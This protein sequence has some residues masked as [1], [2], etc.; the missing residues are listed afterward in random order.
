MNY[1][2]LIY[3]KYVYMYFSH[4]WPLLFGRSWVVIVYQ[5]GVFP[6]GF[7]IRLYF[8][9][10]RIGPTDHIVPILAG[11]ASR[12]TDE[13]FWIFA[14]D[15]RTIGEIAGQHSGAA[16]D[17]IDHFVGTLLRKQPTEKRLCTHIYGYKVNHTF[18]RCHTNFSLPMLTSNSISVNW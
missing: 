9:C 14:D 6:M 15:S 4:L 8:R 16:I 11:F 7:N 10:A 5:S 13:I 12:N 18:H 1:V 2:C 17:Y 3:V